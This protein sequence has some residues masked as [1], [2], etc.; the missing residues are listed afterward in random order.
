MEMKLKATRAKRVE[1]KSL[2][3]PALEGWSLWEFPPNQP[4]HLKQT[5][6]DLGEFAAQEKI[7]KMALAL[8]VKQVFCLSL[9]LTTEDKALLPDLIF[10]Q[11]ERRGLVTRSREETVFDYR[12]VAA[13]EG[14]SLVFI[15]ILPSQLPEV[16]IHNNMEHYDVSA[17]FYSL[18]KD[19]LTLWREGGQLVIA[20]TRNEELVHFQALSAEEVNPATVQEILCLYLELESQHV[21]QAMQGITLWG[22]FSAEEIQLIQATF[23]IVP[24]V[25]E[26]P[27]PRLPSN[28]FVLT[29]HAVQQIQTLQIKEERNRKILKMA[30]VGYGLFLG[31]WAL[32]LLFFYG[33]VH[34][35]KREIKK[36]AGLVQSL[37]ETAARWNALGTALQ[38][39]QYAVEVLYQCARLLPQEGVRFTLFEATDAN[40]VLR[41]EA[42]SVAAASDFFEKLKQNDQLLAFQW[43]MPS[44]IIL[45]NDTAQFQ[46]TGS[47]FN[48]PA[49]P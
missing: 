11:L 20:L 32:Q 39:D 42:T 47:R 6:T 31:L 44:P 29:P 12:V 24:Q 26:M 30:L 8:P 25:A 22:N 33:R 35:I 36:E 40:V 45:P 10:T 15:A 21:I 14:K 19:H 18:E 28:S 13:E 48:A 7:E 1:A 17:R 4:P 37:K 34:L 2:L 49:Q 23:R 3:L 41:G 27:I 5:I 46:I 9:W 43:Q 16:Y 38:P